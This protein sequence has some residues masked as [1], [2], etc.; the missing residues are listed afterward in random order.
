MT[1]RSTTENTAEVPTA[2]HEH[3]C[4]LFD[5]GYL[6]LGLALFESLIEHDG[7][8]KLWV[9]CM[10]DE[11]YRALA[12]INHPLLVPIELNCIEN[13]ALKKVRSERTH[14][15]YCWT[16]TPFLPEYLLRQ[17]AS[18][19]RVTYVDADCYFFSSP[20]RLLEK[21]TDS[22]KEVLITP[23]GYSPEYDQSETAGIFC[24]QF[25]TFTHTPEALEVLIWWQSKCLEWCGSTAEPGRFGDQKYLDVWPTLFGNSVYILDDPTLTLA[26]WNV[27]RLTL[28]NN[29]PCMY[30]FHGFKLYS[31]TKVD[32]N[33]Y[34]KLSPAIIRQFYSPYLARLGAI[35]N[36]LENLDISIAYRSFKPTLGERISRAIHKSRGG[37][38]TGRIKDRLH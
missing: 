22:G 29:K 35:L 36:T 6:P 37:L 15:E 14:G 17:E 28:M 3:Y 1:S 5:S 19:S 34:Y 18:I 23:H 7:S 4:T 26:P 2:T 8:A 27:E 31:S 32:L 9:L 25:M 33:F 13:G 24:V 12:L 16:L 30:H 10:D 20:Q 21:F 38:Q 11:T